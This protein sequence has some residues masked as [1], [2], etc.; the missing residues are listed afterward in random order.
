MSKINNKLDIAKNKNLI[1][2]VAGKSG[3]HLIPAIT[4]A[5]NMLK[6]DDFNKVLFFSTNTPLDKKILGDANFEKD[7]VILNLGNFPGKNLL[8][9]PGFALGF[10]VT[11]L[12]S[13]KHLLF[14]RPKKVISMGGYIS[15][16]VCI[17]AYILRI[18][19]ELFELNSTP[20]KAIKFLAPIA[21][22]INACF[23][24]ALKFLPKNKSFL[25]DYPIRFEKTEF[26][27]TGFE[28][29]KLEPKNLEDSEF[30]KTS[31]GT[32]ISE[33]LNHK[34]GLDNNKVTL[35]VLG[36]S[37]G[38]VSLNNLVKLAIQNNK[39]WNKKIQI[40]HQT[41]EKE[42]SDFEK[43]YKNLGFTAYVVPFSNEIKEFYKLSNVVVCRS[44]AGSIFE[45]L[46]FNKKCITVPLESAAADHQLDNAIEM[47]RRFPDI[48]KMVRQSQGYEAIEKEIKKYIEAFYIE[49]I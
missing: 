44:G 25:A 36:G 37:Q 33:K 35:L 19:V 24:N 9:L 11:F 13:F 42:N 45:T 30:E 43:I 22:K 2:F 28:K 14:K 23:E 17:S 32:N 47:E 16:P 10:F 15:I 6:N 5:K 7:H 26:E 21:T 38:S 39:D 4:V 40:I 31:F 34:Y 48:F 41:G 46:F 8:K 20:G 49:Q 29:T 27:E 1:C 12:K 18:P 3:G